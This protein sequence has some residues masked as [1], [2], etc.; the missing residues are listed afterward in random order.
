[1][2]FARFQRRVA[3]IT[4]R[5]RFLERA[6]ARARGAV[7]ALVGLP[8][9]LVSGLVP[10]RPHE[11]AFG[12]NG[13]RFSDN[14]KHLFLHLATDPRFRCTWIASDPA[15][16]AAVRSLGFAAEARWSP[17]GVRRTLLAGWFVFDGYP[18]DVNF[19]LSR[20]ARL[21]NLWHGIP[22]K[23]IEF[24]ITIG[25]L[26]RVYRSPW[27][28]PIRLAFVDRFRRPD[29]LLTVSPFLS[30]RCFRSAF[31]I[32]A[33][34]CVEV[35]YPRTDLLFRPVDRDALS[36]SIGIDVTSTVIGYFPT[37]RDDGR[38][39]LGEAGF[40][41]DDLDAHLQP[42]GRT[43]VFKA[44]PNLSVPTPPDTGWTNIV[45]LDPSVDLN[46]VLPRCDVLVTDYS[47]VA[48]DFLLLDRPI[49]YFLPDHEQY[50]AG[51]NLYF[52]LD[53]MTAGPIVTTVPALIELLTGALDDE[54]ETRR[55]QLRALLWDGYSGDA[56]IRIADLIVGVSE[57]TH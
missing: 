28:S 27:W 45:V 33:D 17:R 57:A 43:L 41:F 32:G 5:R 39:F 37:W 49:V 20:S 35:G 26:A 1:V 10:R 23:A 50:V 38:D 7:V 48:F 54:H 29:H 9:Y 21:L 6:L 15:T 12:G 52:T 51:R 11:V 19:W 14:A 30:E 16:V 2:A 53:E 4:S 42:T 47:S 25:P 40:S 31:R 3:A 55:A 56:C 18:S 24:D 13:D 36:A 46:D 22:L 44:H 34:R 8:L